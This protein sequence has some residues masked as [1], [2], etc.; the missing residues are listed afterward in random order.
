MRCSTA[1]LLA[2]LAVLTE[3]PLVVFPICLGAALFVEAWRSKRSGRRWSCLAS[4]IAGGLPA[5]LLLGG[6]HYLATGS[7]FRLPYSFEMHEE[8]AYHRQ[9]WGLPIGW[10]KLD[11]VGE[12]LLG[13]RRG[14][15]WYC[16]ILIVA[17]VGWVQMIRLKRSGL[18][19]VIAGVFLGVLWI[20]AGF[21]M[22]DGGWS[23]GPRFLLPAIPLLMLPVGVWLAEPLP[24][25]IPSRILQAAFAFVAIGGATWSTALT[26]AGARVHPGVAEPYRQFVRPAV[27][28][29]RF[30]P[31]YGQ[32][33][34][35]QF[36]A[37]K[38]TGIAVFLA[39]A[40]MLFVAW[41]AER[42][43][44]RTTVPVAADS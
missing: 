29:G 18:A 24:W 27:E 6:Y 25:K 32:W 42:R 28:Q 43:Q 19:A 38:P 13:R 5:A 8:F 44:S 33:L 2:G 41:L 23:A 31:S 10:P 21:P 14:L 30:E 20:N 26:T 40:T 15:L 39:A 22:W 7:P 4:F 16:P 1:G 35:Q 37:T 3:Y 17:P 34:V 36:S 9:G 11:V 12:L